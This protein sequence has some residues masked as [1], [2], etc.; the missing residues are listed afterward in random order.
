[1]NVKEL[2]TTAVEQDAADIFLVPGMP[3]SYK[4]GGRIIYQGQEKIMPEEMDRMITQIYELAKNRDMAKVREHGD[5]DFSFAIPGV[6]RFRANI[7]RQR[8]SLAGIIRVVRFELPDPEAL[9]LPKMIIDVARIDQGNGAGDRS[10]GKRKEHDPGLHHRRD[11][12]DEKRPRD[13]PGGPH[14]VS[15]PA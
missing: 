10:R 9:H 4:I 13:H 11:Q 12:P 5:D 3:F 7:F 14:R 2:L 6:S 8:G 1:M 15:S